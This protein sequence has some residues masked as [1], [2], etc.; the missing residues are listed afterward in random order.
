MEEQGILHEELIGPAFR[1]LTNDMETKEDMLAMME[2]Y[3][4]VAKF[5]VSRQTGRYFVPAQ[6][7]SS[8]ETLQK[9]EPRPDD[10]CVLFIHF[11]DGF[12]PQGLFT[13]LTSRLIRHSASLDC[14]QLPNLYSNGVR[15][16]L[17][18][19]DQ[20]DLILLCGQRFIKVLLQCSVLDASDLV[21][22]AV[23]TS[24]PIQVRGLLEKTLLDLKAEHHWLGNMEY[25]T[26]VRCGVC[27]K[28]CKT[29]GVSSCPRD[30]CLHFVPVGTG[31]RSMQFTC[32]KRF[33][34][35][36]RFTVPGFKSWFLLDTSPGCS[37]VRIMS[38]Q[39][40]FDAHH[41][42]SLFTPKL[43]K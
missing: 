15:F 38:F 2:E 11:L 7:T 23:M 13:H 41:R 26:S 21:T 28:S 4:L 43:K 35:R 36:A 32:G 12:V 34:D 33:G 25:E 40:R 30:E 19:A 14:T 10:P 22:S 27:D 24:L 29:H 20:F 5:P 31:R 9:Q 8:P 3:G 17:G 39:R 37:P 16:V 1:E 18:T 42:F 6:L